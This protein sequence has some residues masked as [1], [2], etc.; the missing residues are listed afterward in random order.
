MDDI[1][2]LNK[3]KQYSMTEVEEVVATNEKKIFF[4]GKDHDTGRMKIRA[5]QGH[6]M[7]V[8]Y[9]NVSA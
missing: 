7:E 8:R 2:A 4:L 5:N 3:G 6:S 9:G 1:L